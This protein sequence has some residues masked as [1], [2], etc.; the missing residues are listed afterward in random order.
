MLIL[1][2]LR[3][4]H[5][6]TRPVIELYAIIGLPKALLYGTRIFGNYDHCVQL[7]MYQTHPHLVYMCSRFYFMI[8]SFGGKSNKIFHELHHCPHA[9]RSEEFMKANQLLTKIRKIALFPV[10]FQLGTRSEFMNIL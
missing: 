6:G 4:T 5:F 2:G 8:I 1:Y 9:Y 3:E 7:F 10:R